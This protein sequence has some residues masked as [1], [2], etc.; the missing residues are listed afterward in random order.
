LLAAYNRQEV[1]GAV[2][3]GEEAERRVNRRAVRVGGQAR[4]KKRKE[5]TELGSRGL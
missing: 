5:K 4:Y 2:V 1:G 3:Q